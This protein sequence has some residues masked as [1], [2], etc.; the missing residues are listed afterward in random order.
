MFNTIPF[1][2]SN[3]EVFPNV[4]PTINPPSFV[5][6]IS[7]IVALIVFVVYNVPL[8]VY[9]RIEL[10]LVSIANPPSFVA[11]IFL[12]VVNS[13]IFLVYFN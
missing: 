5:G 8:I 11:I 2:K 9:L 12:A 10:L 6:A 13:V 3:G 7:F 4:P 1:P